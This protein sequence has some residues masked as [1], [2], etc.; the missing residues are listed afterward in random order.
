MSKFGKANNV[1]GAQAAAA[2]KGS[3]GVADETKAE[4]M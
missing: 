1:A 3:G 2:A 4:P